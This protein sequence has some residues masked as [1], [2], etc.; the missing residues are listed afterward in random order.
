M[1]GDPVVAE[2]HYQTVSDTAPAL[3]AASFGL[4]RVHLSAGRRAKAV[5]VAARLAR[6][7]RF[8]REASIAAIRLLVATPAPTPAPD[9]AS[10]AAPASTPRPPSPEDLIQAEERLGGLTVDVRMRTLMRVEIRHAAPADTR[11]SEL[12]RETA[13]YAASEPDFTALIDLANRLRPPLAWPPRGF[14]PRLGRFAR[15]DQEN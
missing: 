4:A 14:R 12:V 5:E 6:E 15:N 3:G 11:L 9:A 7:F 13:R 1:T 2:L 10:T 8:E